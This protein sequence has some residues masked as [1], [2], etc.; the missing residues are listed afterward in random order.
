M[1]KKESLKA[2]LMMLKEMKERAEKH[3]FD[4][5]SDNC[6]TCPSFSICKEFSG[7]RQTLE[8]SKYSDDVKTDLLAFVAFIKHEY[9][10]L[11]DFDV[12]DALKDEELT[13]WEI[14]NRFDNLL[15]N[16]KNWDKLVETLDDNQLSLLRKTIIDVNQKIIDFLISVQNDNT[17]EM[18]TILSKLRKP[19]QEEKSYEDMTKEELIELL[20]HNK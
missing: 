3:I 7:I 19:K 1:E 20:K 16:F 13:I 10:W 15:R 12:K 6:K 8:S 4:A 9:I 11:D 14:H 18:N 5:N 2:L 17:N